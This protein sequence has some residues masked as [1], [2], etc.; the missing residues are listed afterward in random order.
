MTTAV[1]T[2]RNPDL[3]RVE[4]IVGRE[5]TEAERHIDVLAIDRMLARAKRALVAAIEQEQQRVAAA[6]ADGRPARCDVT[7]A[8]L[9]PLATL[10]A[11]GRR[12]ASLELASLGYP[13]QLAEA[14]DEA[15]RRLAPIVQAL[16]AWLNWLTIRILEEQQHV[17]ARFGSEPAPRN[18]LIDA[19][20]RVLGARSTAAVLVS[21]ALIAGLGQ[22]FEEAE[23]L[24]DGWQYTAVLDTG[25]CDRCRPLDGKTYPST[26]ALFV[27]LPNFGPSRWCLGGSRCRCRAVPLPARPR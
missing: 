22:T 6:I 8:M 1:V 7:A 27:D 10:F 2:G 11:Q 14:E 4:E 13:R 23:D 19:L 17:E 16:R 20:A 24:V 3:A 12:E 18:V 25:T 21:P 9:E 26:A 15:A 5:L